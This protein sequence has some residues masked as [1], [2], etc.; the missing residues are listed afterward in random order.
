MSTAL[1][2]ALPGFAAFTTHHCVTGSM[3]HVMEHGG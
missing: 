2:D 3:R 1:P